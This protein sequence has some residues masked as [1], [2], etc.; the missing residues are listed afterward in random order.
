VV[1]I[2]FRTFHFSFSFFGLP[3]S[4]ALRRQAAIFAFDL[5]RPPLAPPL[6]AKWRAI[7]ASGI[8]TLQFG[9]IILNYGGLQ[10]VTLDN[11]LIVPTDK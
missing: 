6:A 2:N 8:S 5:D 4:L 10:V 11:V 9:Q 7:S 3:P 1:P